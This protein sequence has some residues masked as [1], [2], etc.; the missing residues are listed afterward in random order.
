MLYGLIVQRLPHAFV[1]RR[2]GKLAHLL[3]PMVLALASPFTA[4][5]QT[6]ALAAGAAIAALGTVPGR[7][8]CAACHLVTGAG[9]PDVGIPRLAGLTKSY[10]AAQLD[11]FASGA[12]QNAAMAPYA[13][14]LTPAQRNQVAAYFASLPLPDASDPL[15]TAAATVARGERIFHNGDGVRGLLACSQCHGPS[16]EGVGDFSPRLAGQSGAYVLSQLGDWQSGALRDPKGIYMRS[17]AGHLTE[18]QMEAVAAY[19]AL[20]P[21]KRGKP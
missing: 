15:P 3:V 20:L 6:S 4:A 17:V 11:Y 8:A 14:A 18:P 1:Y 7:A 9:Q 2:S 13:K 12:R 19:V 5:A 16:G 10:I 21:N